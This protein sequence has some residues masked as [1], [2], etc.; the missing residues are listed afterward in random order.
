MVGVE[1]R[2][3]QAVLVAVAQGPVAEP[4]EQEVG[5]LAYENV[6]GK[7]LLGFRVSEVTYRGSAPRSRHGVC[8][9]TVGGEERGIGPGQVLGRDGVAV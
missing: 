6:S 5:A 4:R 7:Q 9:R 2:P 3:G 1:V 8:A